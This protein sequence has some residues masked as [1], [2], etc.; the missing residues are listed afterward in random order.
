M[1]KAYQLIHVIVSTN[2]CHCTNVQLS[3]LYISHEPVL[4]VQVSKFNLLQE[5]SSTCQFVHNHHSLHKQLW[6]ARGSVSGWSLSAWW[7]LT[8]W[9]GRRRLSDY[10][11]LLSSSSIGK[12]LLRTTGWIRDVFWA[13]RW[14][15]QRWS[16]LW[17]GP[18]FVGG[19]GGSIV[20]L[21][22]R[23]P[24]LNLLGHS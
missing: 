13:S 6:Q 9:G 1:L 21:N 10:R 7:R 2:T 12:V 4:T 23:R 11:G 14:N 24:V 5:Q 18:A 20:H 3:Y 16:E 8:S 15:L 22:E 19:G 17:L